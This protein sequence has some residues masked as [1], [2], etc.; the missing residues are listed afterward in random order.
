MGNLG[1]TLLIPSLGR[2]GYAVTP[3]N[4]IVTA[5]GDSI[6][7]ASAAGSGGKAP[8]VAGFSK[9]QAQTINGTGVGGYLTWACILP[10]TGDTSSNGPMLWGGVHATGGAN[11]ATVKT[12]HIDGTDSPA[13]DSPKAGT[14]LVLV[15]ANDVGAIA[16]GGVLDTPTLN[17]WDTNV[18]AI[19]SSLIGS[20]ILPVLLY[21]TPNTGANAQVAITAMN[22]RIPIIAA[23]LNIPYVDVFTPVATGT[24]WTANHNF[25]TNH[26]SVLGAVKMGQAIRDV[27]EPILS[28]FRPTLVSTATKANAEYQWSNGDMQTES[29]TTG[30][31][32]G[33]RVQQNSAWSWTAV[34]AVPTLGTRTGFEG[35]AWTVTKPTG[36]AT[37]TTALSGGAG[38]VPPQFSGSDTFTFGFIDEITSWDLSSQ[39]NAQFS[40][41]AQSEVYARLKLE[42]DTTYNSAV[43]RF[44]WYQTGVIPAGFGTNQN[45]RLS[46]SWGAAAG[47]LRAITN[48]LGHLTLRRNA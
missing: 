21:V 27:V 22:L 46:L 20:G 7:L 5:I 13:N 24:T 33:G 14:C 17:A 28:S 12:S 42:T 16:P 11:T 36:D 2:S 43:K 45:G 39:F 26:P 4:N 18:R 8:G 34:L 19:C 47:T 31:P 29:S 23:A 9:Y 10:K 44:V 15:G 32:Q 30:V 41:A 40:N 38:S 35:K 6:T 25:D 48:H 3:P 1:Q 37:N